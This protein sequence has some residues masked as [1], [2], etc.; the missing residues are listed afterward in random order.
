MLTLF[1]ITAAEVHPLLAEDEEVPA[2]VDKHNCALSDF[3]SY[4]S[5]PNP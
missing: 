5:N 1:G 4:I 3:T 2:D